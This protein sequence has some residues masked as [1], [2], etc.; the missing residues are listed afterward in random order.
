[1]STIQLNLWGVLLA[2]C[3]LHGLI[4]AGILFIKRK[5]DKASLTSLAIL[6]LCVAFL[7]VEY[8]IRVAGLS[9]R[10]PH[11]MYS[12]FPLWY[13][14]G[15]MLFFYIQSSI[16]R[17]YKFRIKTMPHFAPFFVSIIILLPFYGINGDLKLEAM[18]ISSANQTIS[19]QWLLLLW[20]YIIQTASYVFVC[21]KKLIKRERDLKNLI[22]DTNLIQIEWQKKLILVFLIYLVSDF[23][24]TFYLIITNKYPD[25]FEYLSA[26]VISI[27]IYFIG[28]TALFQSVKLFGIQEIMKKKYSKSSLKE[29]EIKSITTVLNRIMQDEKP[30]MNNE[31]KLSDLA[32]TMNISNHKLSQIINQ[33]FR[34]SFYD[35]INTFRVREVKN[36]LTN[37]RYRNWTI[38][39][40][41]YDAGFNSNTSFYRIFKKN[42][43]M[44]PAVFVH[45]NT[46]KVIA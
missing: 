22:S 42:T 21:I 19:P 33:N 3:A 36:R 44:T 41:A 8:T 5:D 20:I 23:S 15:P 38:L 13:L 7:L 46:T 2:F 35:Y 39:A 32:S 16:E 1:M 14:I 45:K 27:F 11:T 30:Y 34:I 12:T 29:E 43:G 25:W 40:I 18:A 4:L 9:A 31:L 10:F 26:I 28:Y 6:L 24:T 17:N 37:P